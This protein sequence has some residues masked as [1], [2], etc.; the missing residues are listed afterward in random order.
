LRVGDLARVAGLSPYQFDQRIR[1]LFRLSTGQLLLKFRMDSA[2]EYLRDTD[3][4]LTQVALDCGFADQSA[5]TRQFR[6]TTGLTPGEYR[7]TFLAARR[8]C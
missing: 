6:R 8:T 4:P 2:A 1:R 5:F 3:R 7:R